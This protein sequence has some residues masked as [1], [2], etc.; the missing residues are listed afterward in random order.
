MSKKKDENDILQNIE[1]LIHGMDTEEPSDEM[2]QSIVPTHSYK[3]KDKVSL[4]LVNEH[5]VNA[6]EQYLQME[7]KGSAP[8]TT[9]L[10]VA[11][12]LGKIS[13]IDKVQMSE[14]FNYFDKAVFDAI[15]S[16][17]NVGN[18]IMSLRM[19]FRTMVGKS[20]DYHPSPKQLEMV[21]ISIEKMRNMDV[22]IDRTEEANNFRLKPADADVRK[23]ILN[24]KFIALRYIMANING[25]ETEAIQ[26]LST[27]V[28]LSY[29]SSRRQIASVPMEVLST[30]VSK[31]ADAIASQEYMMHR[32]EAMKSS[33]RLSRVILFEKILNSI[34]KKNRENVHTQRSFI[35]SFRENII[36][37]LDYWKKVNYITDYQILG[38]GRKNKYYKIE[39]SI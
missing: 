17:M 35:R 33:P 10:S 2:Q 29:A 27:P 38:N 9:K 16:L 23:F 36:K 24:E 13:R 1:N 5:I 26:V 25:S 6:G 20:S 21:R 7:K 34:P 14:D 8:V 19:I 22:Y 4:T 37:I 12:D 32:I 11:L 39:I 31:N 18:Q 28:L 15:V 30:P 3:T